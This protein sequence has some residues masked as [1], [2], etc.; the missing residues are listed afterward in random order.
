VFIRC[1]SLLLDF[2]SNATRCS[3]D[4]SST[5]AAP[6]SP[7]SFI[8]CASSLSRRPPLFSPS[9]ARPPGHLFLLPC[10]LQPNQACPSSDFPSLGA[11]SAARC[12][13][14]ESLVSCARVLG[15]SLEL[16][17]PWSAPSLL[18]PAR[19]CTLD[20]LPL[21]WW[22]CALPPVDLPC[23]WP[24]PAP[25]RVPV[26]AKPSS[27]L[28]HACFLHAAPLPCSAFHRR[29]WSRSPSPWSRPAGVFSLLGF[30]CRSPRSRFPLF[31]ACTPFRVRVRS[32]PSSPVDW[33]CCC[34]SLYSCRSLVAAPSGAL[35]ARATCYFFACRA[36]EFSLLA[37]ACRVSAS[38]SSFPCRPLC[39][40]CR[41][42]RRGIVVELP[43]CRARQ[44]IGSRPA[45]L[46]C[47]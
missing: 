3:G 15:P 44:I 21:P 43:R 18:L 47:R 13:C 4:F 42:A 27:F 17:P 5:F 12:S 41:S 26:L 24:V 10:A 19:S 46:S 2:S 25:V 30:D 8:P 7:A 23:A 34:A 22:S 45:R 6:L 20:F 35:C 9:S 1:R 37:T 11:V 38:S 28:V 36:H 33:F 14:R 31:L 16:A 29:R 32:V 39:C 40:L